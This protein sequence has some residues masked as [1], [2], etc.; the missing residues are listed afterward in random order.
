MTNL[1]I[2]HH[3][4][5]IIYRYWH[6]ALCGSYGLLN[7]TVADAV[8]KNRFVLTIGFMCTWF[9]LFEVSRPFKQYR[10]SQLYVLYK[11]IKPTP[12]CR[13]NSGIIGSVGMIATILCTGNT[14]S[15]C[16]TPISSRVPVKSNACAA[17]AATPA[18]KS[19]TAWSRLC[20]ASHG[21]AFRID[22]W[23]LS[24]SGLLGTPFSRW[25]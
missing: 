5:I 25:N 16:A 17:Q 14:Y 9:R 15:P 4:Y 3:I 7:L 18:R 1:A 2:L 24:N 11:N 21:W 23:N 10:E 22:Y 12:M 20:E 6:C 13:K 8:K 19:Q